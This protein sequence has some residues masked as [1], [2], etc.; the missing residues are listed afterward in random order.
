M[1]TFW[2]LF[3][4]QDLESS[5]DDEEDFQSARKQFQQARSVSTASRKTLS[6]FDMDNKDDN[7]RNSVPFVRQITEDGKAKL[8]IYRPTTNPIYI[9]TQVSVRLPRYVPWLS[10]LN[11]KSC[12]LIPRCEIQTRSSYF[13]RL[14]TRA[15]SRNKPRDIES[16][17]DAFVIRNR[18]DDCMITKI[19]IFLDI[20]CGG[21]DKTINFNWR[22]RHKIRKNNFRRWFS[23]EFWVRKS[24]FCHAG[25]RFINILRELVI[26]DSSA[27]QNSFP[28]QLSYRS[29]WWKQKPCD[30]KLMSMLSW[31]DLITQIYFQVNKV[32][33]FWITLHSFQKIFFKWI[34]F[35]NH[36]WAVVVGADNLKITGEDNFI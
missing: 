17:Y 31:D 11:I 8:E 22:H 35:I 23:P 3:V 10:T 7:L 36:V 28:Y 12:A 9:Y 4:F 32:G 5:S 24:I 2:W 30:V 33:S 21:C 19:K 15:C 26:R 6:F 18:V 14:I 29:R 34:D 25:L 16:S 1:I 20:C 27:T 13:L